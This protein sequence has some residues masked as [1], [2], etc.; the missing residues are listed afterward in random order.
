LLHSTISTISSLTTYSFTSLLN[1]TSN[2]LTLISFNVNLSLP[3]L[4]LS[5]YSYNTISKDL[6]NFQT[7][8]IDSSVSTG[9]AFSDSTTY[10]RFIRFSNPLISYDYKCG[11][12]L[13][14][15]EQLYPSLML[16]YIEVARGIR[17]AP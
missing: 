7:S 5:A 15:W 9:D 17:K 4:N 14:I 3:Y 13:G 16:S 8:S 1:L 6:V 11:N 2:V 12:Y 10:G